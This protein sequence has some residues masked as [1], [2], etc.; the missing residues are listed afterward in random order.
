MTNPKRPKIL[1]V[2]DRKENLIALRKVLSGLE[3]DV[4]EAENGNDAL[5]ATLSNRFALAMRRLLFR[6]HYRR[7]YRSDRRG[8]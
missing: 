4:V 1:I 8:P 3:I 6:P 5:T 2:D 7:R